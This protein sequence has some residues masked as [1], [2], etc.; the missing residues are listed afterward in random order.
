MLRPKGENVFLATV[1]VSVLFAVLLIVSAGGKF[2]G[3]EMQMATMRKVGFPVDKVWLLACAELAGAG[4]LALGLFWWPLGAAAGA[5][6]VAYFIGAAGS[7][8]RAGDQ[9]GMGGAV[10]LLVLA[11]AALTLRAVT[12]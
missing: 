1:I 12:S 5:G 4:G 11:V 8:V 9:R 7:H 10:L 3:Q 2:T 6:L